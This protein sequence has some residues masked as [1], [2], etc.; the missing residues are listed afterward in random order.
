MLTSDK[1]KEILK[2]YGPITLA[3][4]VVL[5]AGVAIGWEMKPD[6]VKIEEKLKVVEVEKQVLVVQEK[7]KVE[8][9]KVKDTQIVERYHREKVEEKKPDGTVTVREVEDRNIDSHVKEKENTVEVKVVEVEKKV[10]IEKEKEV[11]KKIDPVLSQW[12]VGLIAGAS[13]DTGE[14]PNSTNV[15]AGAEVERR[16]IG[17]FWAGIWISGESPTSQFHLQEVNVGLKLAAEF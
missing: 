11:I 10:Y 14:F 7:V 5:C 6:Q 8:I 1:L 2:K 12:H 4:I 9:V 3:L 16:I 13:L 15:I 17:P